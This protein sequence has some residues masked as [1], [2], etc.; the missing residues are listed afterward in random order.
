VLQHLR[1]LGL[2]G[3]GMIGCAGPGGPPVPE[4]CSDADYFE[5]EACDEAYCGEPVVRMGVGRD[6]HVP[7]ADGDSVTLVYGTQ[8]GFHLDASVEMENLCPVVFLRL[9]LDVREPGATEWREAWADERH[10][11]TVR[12]EPTLSSRQVLWGGQATPPCEHYPEYDPP[13]KRRVPPTCLGDPERTGSEGR[14]DELEV[15]LRYEAED[16][17]GRLGRAAVELDVDCCVFGG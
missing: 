16:H 13:G 17:N 14:L 10:V 1:F 2:V 12:P 8:G 6:E 15:R 5:A 11:Q 3:L 7:A 4:D 9:G